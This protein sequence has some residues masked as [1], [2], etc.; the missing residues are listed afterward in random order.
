MQSTYGCHGRSLRDL[1]KLRSS[2]RRRL[3]SQ[4]RSGGNADRLLIEPGTTTVLAENEGP[5]LDQPRLVPGG[6]AAR[7]TE[8]TWNH[9]REPF[10][11]V[12]R[13]AL[14]ITWDGRSIRAPR[15]R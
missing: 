11:N 14:S 3:S 9:G 2:R 7:A 6:D 12:R 5:S 15:Y 1:P 8:P 4:D 13:L 10:D